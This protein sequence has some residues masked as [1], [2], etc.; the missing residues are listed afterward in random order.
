MLINTRH[1]FCIQVQ[2][3]RQPVCRLLPV[4]TLQDSY[5]T[6]QFYKT[7]LFAAQRAFNVNTI[8]L[9][10][11]KRTTQN[12]LAAIQKADRTTQS[13]VNACTP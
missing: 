5:L 13:R 8:G 11:L 7:L 2:I 9:A 1:R 10:S 3:T 4:K 12:T 6:T